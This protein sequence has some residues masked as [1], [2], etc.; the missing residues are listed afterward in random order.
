MNI[1]VISGSPRTTESLTNVVASTIYET[2]KQF[3]EESEIW[4]L[5]ERP[6]PTADPKYHKNPL[7]DENPEAVKKFAKSVDNA[8]VIVLVS[9]VYNGSY[10]SHLKNALDS[11][12]WDH[13]RGKQVLL[14]SQGNPASAGIVVSHLNEVARTLQGNVHNSYLVIDRSH[15]DVKSQEITRRESLDRIDSVLSQLS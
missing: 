1:L 2:S 6:L 7:A 11:L 12:R 5:S 3:F 15:I 14:S 13:F 8:E 10:S 4:L 9:P